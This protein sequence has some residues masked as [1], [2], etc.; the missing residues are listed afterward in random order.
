MVLEPC[1]LPKP[2]TPKSRLKGTGLAVK[3][4]QLGVEV[5]FSLIFEGLEFGV[6]GMRVWA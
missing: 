1:G 5:F 2:N 4:L 6:G 3:D